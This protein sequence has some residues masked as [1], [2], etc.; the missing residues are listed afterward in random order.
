VVVFA[1]AKACP[2]ELKLPD[3]QNALSSMRFSP[4]W[5]LSEA[6]SVILNVRLVLNAI[7][8]AVWAV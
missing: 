3:L 4:P 6:S 8:T 2:I 7:E 1:A 5:N